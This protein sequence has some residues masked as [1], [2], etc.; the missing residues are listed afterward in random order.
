MSNEW[1]NVDGEKWRDTVRRVV[2][3][4]NSNHLEEWEVLSQIAYEFEKV[5]AAKDAEIE[6]LKKALGKIN[7][8]RNSI[9][10]AQS[11]NWSEHIY[12]LVAAL[13]E[14]G[15]DGLPYPECKKNIG[16]L[17][18]RNAKCEAEIERLK[19]RNE[20]LEKVLDDLEEEDARNFESSRNWD[21]IDAHMPTYAAYLRERVASGD[22]RPPESGVQSGVQNPEEGCKSA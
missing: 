20:F 3:I 9:V 12:P 14:V 19:A 13:S 17:L 15:I 2:D 10:G 4:C 18:D 7:A 11:V 8:I 5:V 22:N 6:R 21:Y 1:R 16:T